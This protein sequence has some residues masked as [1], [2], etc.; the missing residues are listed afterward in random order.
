MLLFISTTY[1]YTMLSFSV[2]WCYIPS[3]PSRRP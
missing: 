1:T 3:N 2:Y